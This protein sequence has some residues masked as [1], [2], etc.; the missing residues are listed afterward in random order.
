M[1]FLR[2]CKRKNSSRGLAIVASV[3]LLALYLSGTLEANLFHTALHAP[4]EAS[5]HSEANESNGCHQS[6]YH[7]QAAKSCEH[8]SHIVFSKKCPLCHLS[9]QTFHLHNSNTQSEFNISSQ[10]LSGDGNAQIFG[11][12]VTLLPSRAPPIS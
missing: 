11:H 2:S 12:S 8:K 1:Q 9:F 6:I 7:N 10:E 3:S 5:L 4:E